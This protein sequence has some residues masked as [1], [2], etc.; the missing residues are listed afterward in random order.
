[1]RNGKRLDPPDLGVFHK[2][3]RQFPV[4]E[5][6]AYAGQFVTWSPDGTRIQASA[7]SMEAVEEKLIAAGIDASQ[8]VGDYFDPEN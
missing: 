2:N 6:A 5:L 8:A 7:E 4:E 3:R 1:M